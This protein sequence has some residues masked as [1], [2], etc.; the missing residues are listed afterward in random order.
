MCH[1]QIFAVMC[2]WDAVQN[3]LELQAAA[4]WNQSLSI[5]P[6]ADCSK[7]TPTRRGLSHT[8]FCRSCDGCTCRQNWQSAPLWRHGGGFGILSQIWNMWPGSYWVVEELEGGVVGDSRINRKHNVHSPAL[9][10]LSGTDTQA[11]VS[12]FGCVFELNVDCTIMLIGGCEWWSDTEG[13]PPKTDL[14]VRT[15]LISLVNM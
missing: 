13:I 14:F 15:V 12:L 2:A 5:A 7:S 9:N 8:W 10:T 11:T 4:V 1:I 6:N 3:V